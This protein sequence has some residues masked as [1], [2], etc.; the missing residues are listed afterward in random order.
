[1]FLLGKTLIFYMI[2]NDKFLKFSTSSSLINNYGGACKKLLTI[3]K[4]ELVYLMVWFQ[5]AAIYL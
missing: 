2:L 1:M 5:M 4:V 3:V